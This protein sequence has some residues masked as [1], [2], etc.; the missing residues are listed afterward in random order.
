MA[1]ELILASVM[2]GHRGGGTG[3]QR[4]MGKCRPAMFI[5]ETVT[6]GRPAM[7]EVRTMRKGG[8]AMLEVRTMRKG[9]PVCPDAGA[10]KARIVQ[11]ADPSAQTTDP[12]A[13]TT[14][15][16]YAGTTETA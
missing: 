5:R 9:R 2:C 6:E 11:C 16:A 15:V 10:G 3:G 8:P 12:S 4:R 14:H 7:L 13:Y 1:P